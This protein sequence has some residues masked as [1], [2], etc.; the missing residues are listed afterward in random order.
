MLESRGPFF[1][2]IAGDKMQC[3]SPFLAITRETSAYYSTITKT[4]QRDTSVRVEVTQSLPC[5]SSSDC[6]QL[7]KPVAPR[8]IRRHAPGTNPLQPGLHRETKGFIHL[9]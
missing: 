3:I 1:A 8:P 9:R 2:G 6:R 5:R 7:F 4:S